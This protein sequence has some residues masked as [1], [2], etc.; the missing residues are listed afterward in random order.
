MVDEL[1]CADLCLDGTGG[2]PSSDVSVCVC[3]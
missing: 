3:V 1:N 2:T